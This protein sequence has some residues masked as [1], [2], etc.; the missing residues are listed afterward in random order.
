MGKVKVGK[1]SIG[2]KE[3]VT[4]IAGPC[5]IETEELLFQVAKTLK[6]ITAELGLGFIFK[7]SYDKANRMSYSSYRG[8]GVEKGMKMLANLK[9]ELGIPIVVDVHKVTEI[10]LVS[11]TADMLQ[12]PAFLC[13]QTDLVVEAARTMLPL[14]IKKGQ[15]MSPEDMKYIAEK[16]GKVGNNQIVLCE[17]GTFFGYH[18]LVVDF[19]SIPIMCSLGYPVSF[20]F[21]HSLQSPGA[22][23]G[24]SGGKGKFAEHYAKCGVVSGADALFFETHPD[25]ASSPSDAAVIFPLEKVKNLLTKVKKLCSIKKKEKI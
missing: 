12:I 3:D 14:H 24:A 19:R 2:D 15:F 25:P 13:R 22:K 11:Q 1:V 17:R 18:D 8:P 6:S 10:E 5:V 20:D 21:T 9:K 4:I 16:A 23:G 7:C